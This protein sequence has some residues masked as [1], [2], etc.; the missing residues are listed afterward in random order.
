MKFCL[1]CLFADRLFACKCGR[2]GPYGC[3]VYLTVDREILFVLFVC[4]PSRTPVPT[5]FVVYLTVDRGILLYCSFTGM[6]V[7][8]Y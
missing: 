4:G 5:V 8:V 7:I 2:I 1:C 3:I 6:A